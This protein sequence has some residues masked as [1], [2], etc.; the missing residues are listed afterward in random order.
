VLCYVVALTSVSRKKLI[1]L[2]AGEENVADTL[3][4]DL[5]PIGMPK[6]SLADIYDFALRPSDK[7]KL[8]LK[9]KVVMEAFTNSVSLGNPSLRDF[10]FYNGSIVNSTNFVEYLFSNP[11]DRKKL[12]V[13]FNGEK[14]VPPCNGKPINPEHGAVVIEYREF[15]SGDHTLAR[16]LSSLKKERAQYLKLYTAK[17]TSSAVQ[18]VGFAGKHPQQQQKSQREIKALQQELQNQEE[19]LKYLEELQRQTTLLQQ[20]LQEKWQ[21]SAYLLKFQEQL[22]VI[23]KKLQ[24]GG[25]LAY[26]HKPQPQGKKASDVRKPY[27]EPNKEHQAAGGDLAQPNNQVMIYGNTD[28]H[29]TRHLQNSTNSS[30][31]RKISSTDG[32]K[33]EISH[34]DIK[35][36]PGFSELNILG[37]EMVTIISIVGN[38]RSSIDTY[39]RVV[40]ILFKYKDKLFGPTGII[41]ENEGQ[42]TVTKFSGGFCASGFKLSELSNYI[43]QQYKKKNSQS[44]A[45]GRQPDSSTAEASSAKSGGGY[46]RAHQLDESPIK[47]VKASTITISNPARP[48][49]AYKAKES[50]W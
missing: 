31:K 49:H 15:D 39:S 27:V 4:K 48:A 9:K 22:A 26:N 13:K 42:I 24:Q 25:G 23:E 41:G 7:K 21:D 14:P 30:K 37:V 33:K 32:V 5:F 17:R 35:K 28:T 11:S 3:N 50:K 18:E 47:R 36:I 16:T 44:R 40:K 2:F 29:S 38:T 20:E 34:E 6:A 45:I 43:N 1:S 12:E 8:K 19:G 10:K 46:S